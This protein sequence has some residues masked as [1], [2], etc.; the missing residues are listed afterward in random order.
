MAMS[1]FTTMRLCAATLWGTMMVSAIAA[2]PTGPTTA[3]A[4]PTTRPAVAPPA[5]SPAPAL[6]HELSVPREFTGALQ[7]RAVDVLMPSSPWSLNLATAPRP[8]PVAVAPTRWILPA[9]QP[10]HRALLPLLE[11]QTPAP[12][13]SADSHALPAATAV[14]PPPPRLAATAPLSVPTNAL[15]VGIELPL[16]ARQRP[17]PVHRPVLP[18]ADRSGLSETPPLPPLRTSPVPVDAERLQRNL[19]ALPAPHV[20]RL[21]AD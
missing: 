4:P 11:R 17:L 6:P 21:D 19:R 1:L 7:S 13:I 8:A 10:R 5:T 18:L 3:P 20:Q 14:P 16:L 12:R 15:P 2:Q 9:M